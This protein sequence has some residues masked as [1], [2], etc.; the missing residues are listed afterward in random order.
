LG[1]PSST[2]CDVNNDRQL[3]IGKTFQVKWV[4]TGH[5]RFLGAEFKAVTVPQTKYAKQSCNAICEEPAERTRGGV[6]V[7]P[8]G[9]G[10][11][12]I[13][14]EIPPDGFL[15]DPDGGFVVDP[16]GGKIPIL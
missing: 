12:P 1:E 9:G 2:P 7:S 3:R 15:I 10:P 13:Q 8:T 6:I 11:A 4:I 16:D 14:P 5:C